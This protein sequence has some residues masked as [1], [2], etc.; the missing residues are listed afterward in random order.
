[1]RCSS[2]RSKV[3]TRRCRRWAARV[4]RL[5]AR[6][7]R[8]WS[9]ARG[10]KVGCRRGAEQREERRVRR[11]RRRGRW[12]ARVARLQARARRLWSEARGEKKVGCRRGAEQREGRRVRRR[13]WRRGRWAA[14]EEVVVVRRQ[15]EGAGEGNREETETGWTAY[16]AHTHAAR[17]LLGADGGQ[18]R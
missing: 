12:A 5:Q 13:R 1:M 7:R 14:V 2:Q 9:E 8:L 6:A 4:A 17:A 3:V 16:A 18:G 15:T 11:R 10:E